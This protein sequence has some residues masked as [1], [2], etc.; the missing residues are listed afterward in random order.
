MSNSVKISDFWQLT[1]AVAGIYKCACIISVYICRFCSTQLYAA[2]KFHCKN[3]EFVI[4]VE[5]KHFY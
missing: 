3:F 2:T 1:V 5:S 4:A